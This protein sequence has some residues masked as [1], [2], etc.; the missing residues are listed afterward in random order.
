MAE[1]LS[2]VVAAGGLVVPLYDELAYND[3]ISGRV[4]WGV[5]GDADDLGTLNLIDSAAVFRAVAAIR[6]GRRV[7]LSLPLDIPDPPLSAR[8]SSGPELQRRFVHHRIKLRP[9][10]NDD[11]LDGYFLQSSTQIDGL[12]HVGGRG[13]VYYGGV[14]EEDLNG[15]DRLG[16]DHIASAGLVTRGV[17]A[18]VSRFGPEVGWDGSAAITAEILAR[19]LDREGVQLERGDALLVR[20]G[21]LEEYLAADDLRRAALSEGATSAGLAAGE[22]MASWLW[23]HRVAVLGADNPGVEVIPGEKGQFLHRRLITGL[24]MPLIEWL[25]LEELS[26]AFAPEERYDCFLAIVPLNLRRAAGSPA[27]ALA[28]C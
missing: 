9:T 6:H 1:P 28:V 4:S 23:D 19:V 16:V 24:G 8:L 13:P 3:A 25:D 17:L 27:N 5:F 12:R 20:T 15:T 21:Y 10:I 14:T 11:Y 18:D 7:N 2:E 22:T 26:R